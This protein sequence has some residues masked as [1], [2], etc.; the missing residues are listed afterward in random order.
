MKN[1][2]KICLL[3]IALISFGKA[4][5]QRT[6]VTFY[7]TMGNIKVLLTDSLTPRTVD[8]FLSLVSKKFYDG[9]LFHRVI[10]NFMIQGGDPLGNGTGGPGW[11]IPDEFHSS[12]K[13][14][15]GALSMA[16]SGPNTN[17]SQYFINL[18]VNSHLDNKHTVF[19]MVTS[20]FNIV[21]NIGKVAKDANDK[22]LTPVKTDSIRITKFPT[23]VNNIHPEDF[24]IYP[25]PS[26]GI[27][28]IDL[29]NASTKVEILNVTGQS[30]F[31]TEGKRS[32]KVDISKQPIGLYIVRLSNQQ[33]TTESRIVKQ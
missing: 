12:L 2:L 33:G 29:P 4:Q 24:H 17:G 32:V 27:F 9:L 1:L 11:Q 5:A 25:N 10:D 21:Q 20:G 19:G 28:T 6:E 18:V 31:N 8:S 13:N 7:T 23:T 30:V 22:P 26:N 16:N 3:A 15:P 14:V